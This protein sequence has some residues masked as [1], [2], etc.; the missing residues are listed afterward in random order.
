MISVPKPETSYIRLG[1]RSHA[2]G[3]FHELVPAGKGL[4]VDT[5]YKVLAN[6]LIVNIT[7]AWEMAIALTDKNDE[8]KLVSHRFPQFKF[9]DRFYPLFFKYDILN[10]RFQHE[11]VIASPGGAGRNRVLKKNEFLAIKRYIPKNICEQQ[12]I[13]QTFFVLDN[14]ITLHQRKLNTLKR[15]VVT[16]D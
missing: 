5:M 12:K 10:K 8:G 2:K 6:H 7:F 11:V 15:I 3:T 16:I 9:K 14:L 1:I 13:A 4:E